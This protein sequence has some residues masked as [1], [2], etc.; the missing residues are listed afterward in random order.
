MEQRTTII[1]LVVKGLAISS[2]FYEEEF[3][4]KKTK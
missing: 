1:G 4:W 3:G 2:A